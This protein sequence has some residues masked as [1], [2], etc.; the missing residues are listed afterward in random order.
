M[1][2]PGINQHFQKQYPC[3]LAVG[4]HDPSSGAGIL[5]DAQTLFA[6]KTW[7]IT[8]VTA[9]TSQNSQAV[10]RID[11]QNADAFYEQLEVLT[12]DLPPAA[13]KL[14]MTGS[15][16]IQEALAAWLARNPRLPFVLDPVITSTSGS[17][18]TGQQQLE[19]LREELLPKASLITPNLPELEQL[20]PGHQSIEEKAWRLLQSGAKA[21]LVTGTHAASK[22]VRNQ[23]FIQAGR[24]PITSRWPRLPHEYHGSGCT[25]ASALAAL[26]ARGEALETASNLAQDFTWE[27]LKQ[28]LQLSDGPHLPLRIREEEDV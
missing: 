11:P 18:L 2:E 5:A 13:V 4:G 9:L 10:T 27:S 28:G 8:L 12:S 14:G 21:V 3:V 26:L 16:A 22:A 19:H 25:L 17:D 15:L 1:L 24:P 6:F 23:L 7:P 20:V